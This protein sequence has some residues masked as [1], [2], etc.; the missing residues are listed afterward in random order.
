MS[1]MMNTGKAGTADSLKTMTEKEY[2]SH[3]GVNFST[4]K[5]MQKSPMHYFWALDN[6]GEDTP[7]L[8]MGRAV[9]VAVLQQPMFDRTYAVMPEGIDRR[10][11]EGKAAWAEFAESVGDRETLTVEEFDECMRIRS[12]IRWSTK[13]DFRE[14][15]TET[16]LFWNDPRTGIECKCRVD[17][18]REEEDKFL[19][20][21]LK[22]TTDADLKSFTR[23]ALSYGYHMQAAH[24]IT[25]VM[26]NGL[27]H[28]KPVEWIFLAVEKK[29]PYAVNVIKAMPDFVN[30][31]RLA[32]DE[33]M[34]E[35]EV[36]RRLDQW[37]GYGT[38]EMSLPGW[39]KR[40]EE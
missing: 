16:P 23:S 39:M 37:P 3:P 17:A 30:E 19:I 36:C 34:D 22:T 28:G 26:E 21:D 20:V 24:Y 1:E 4:L 6:P 14:W 11:K 5:L 15:M 9:H 25:G 7:A 18:M 29:P 12:S 2:R 31:G 32:L 10:T 27:N 40:N 38:C 35:L 33:L 8:K 13:W